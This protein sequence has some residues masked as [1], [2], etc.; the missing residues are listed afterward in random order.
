[1][2][3][4]SVKPDK[5]VWF[6]S[7]ERAGLTREAASAAMEYISEDRIQ[8]IESDKSSPHPDEVLAMA[9]VYHDPILTNLY[10]T[11]ECPIGEKYVPKISQSELSAIVLEILDSVR[12]LE[13]CRDRLVEIAADGVISREERPDLEKIA[14]QLERVSA[15]ASTLRLWMEQKLDQPEA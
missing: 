11:Q 1:M 12:G 10:C 3:R 6:L 5:N 15:A 4:R 14:G 7:R 9:R 2:P 13:G 8:R